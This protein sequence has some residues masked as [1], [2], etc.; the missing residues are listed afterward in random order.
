MKAKELRGT[1][2]TIDAIGRRMTRFELKIVLNA[3]GFDGKVSSG[4]NAS[5]RVLG[6]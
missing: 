5:G 1:G 2:T 4:Y 3:D 6:E